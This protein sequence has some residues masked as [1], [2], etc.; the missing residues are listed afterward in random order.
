MKKNILIVT[1]G[2]GVGGIEN[3]VM[4][5]VRYCNRDLFS[6]DFLLYGEYI[7]EYEQEAMQYGCRIIHIRYSKNYFRLYNTIKRVLDVNPGYDIVYAHTFFNSGLVMRAAKKCGVPKCIVHAHSSM[8]SNDQSI[9][10]RIFQ[11][12]MRNWITSYSDIRLACSKQAGEFFFGSKTPYRVIKNGIK[13][14]RFAFSTEKRQQ[15]RKQLNLENSFVIGNVGR[16]SKEKNHM[17][18]IDVFHELLRIGPNNSKLLIVGGGSLYSELKSHIVQLG[19]EQDVILT[20]VRSD[21]PELMLAMDMFL[22]PSIHEGLG[23]GAIEAQASGLITVCSDTVPDEVKITNLVHFL[24]LSE[25]AKAWAE[26]IVLYMNNY[27][28]RDRIA[29]IIAAGYDLECMVSQIEHIFLE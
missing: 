18:L 23:I 14:D 16:L 21:V 24:P 15:I 3:V 9:N 19:M 17:F 4:N 13:V 28:R 6:I 25:G 26:K 8:R 12:L 10:R 22:F 11:A 20:G 27:G 2:L 7:G 1:G 5:F 29:D